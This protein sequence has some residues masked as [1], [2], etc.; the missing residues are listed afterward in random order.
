MTVVSCAPIVRRMSRSWRGLRVADVVLA[1]VFWA[2]ALVLLRWPLPDD[3]VSGRGS[4]QRACRVGCDASAGVP[5]GRA[6]A[7]RVRGDRNAGRPRAARSAPGDLSARPRRARS[8]PTPWAP[9]PPC[10]RLR[11]TLPLAVASVLVAAE[12]GTGGNA[13]PDPVAT[14]VLLTVVWLVGWFGPRPPRAGDIA[15]APGGDTRRRAGAAGA[16]RRPGR[17]AAHRPRAARLGLAQPRRH[18]HAGRRG[19]GGHR[20]PSRGGRPRRWRPSSGSPAHGAD[21]DALAAAGA[22]RRRGCSGACAAARARR[23]RRPD[24]RAPRPPA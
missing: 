22:R 3:V 23:A 7:G 8:R 5:E 19:A 21:R 6:G 15:A 14:L 2:V 1:L 13:S 16:S 12:R 11:R 9:M 20:S 18:P 10:E 17:A 4:A 24:R